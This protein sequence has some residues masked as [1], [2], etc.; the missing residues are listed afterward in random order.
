MYGWQP[1]SVDLYQRSACNIQTSRASSLVW[2]YLR[3]VIVMFVCIWLH[4]AWFA[5]T[6]NSIYLI[7]NCSSTLTFFALILL[8]INSTSTI[9]YVNSPTFSPHLTT[10]TLRAKPPPPLWPRRRLP[11]RQRLL[12]NLPRSRN[13]RKFIWEMIRYDSQAIAY[14]VVSWWH[15]MGFQSSGYV[16]DMCYYY[17]VYQPCNN[18]SENLEY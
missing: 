10:L 8:C 15:V 2:F 9:Y 5:W 7:F 11:R 1:L 12:W 16:V 3:R 13:V 4:G 6:W 17:A 14:H 18:L